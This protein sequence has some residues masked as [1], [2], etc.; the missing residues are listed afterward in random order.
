MCTADRIQ[1]ATSPWYVYRRLIAYCLTIVEPIKSK[2]TKWKDSKEETEK[3]KMRV[4]KHKILWPF[5]SL[6]FLFLTV[7]LTVFDIF[8]VASLPW[9]YGC[10][11]RL[12]DL[13]IGDKIVKAHSWQG[14]I[15][16]MHF[17]HIHNYFLCFN[18]LFWRPLLHT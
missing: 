13:A 16:W 12:R 8:S 6:L 7:C 1:N 9:N 15:T 3:E 5:P 18:D 11:K 10:N 17:G 2:V 14:T 4:P